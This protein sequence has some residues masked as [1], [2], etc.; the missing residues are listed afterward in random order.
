MNNYEMIKSLDE[1]DLAIFLS[2][3]IKNAN[4]WLQGIQEQMR[5]LAEDACMTKE[6]F[7]EIRKTFNL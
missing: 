5:F 2:V 6:D 1:T 4:N 3:D 7:E